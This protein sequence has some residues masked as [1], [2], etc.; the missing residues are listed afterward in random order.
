MEALY[1]MESPEQV[2][3]RRGIAVEDLIANYNVGE[4]VWGTQT[5]QH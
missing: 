2:A 4:R 3:T 5:A 1:Q